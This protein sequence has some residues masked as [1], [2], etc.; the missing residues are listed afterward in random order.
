MLP[1][2]QTAPPG[3]VERMGPPE[4]EV[5]LEEAEQLTS[6][7]RSV[8]GEQVAALQSTPERAGE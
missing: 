2:Q 7:Q 5:Q 4:P 6:R 1:A 3:W 8:Q